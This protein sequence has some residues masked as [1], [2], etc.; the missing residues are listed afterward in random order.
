M[1]DSGNHEYYTIKV[2]TRYYEIIYSEFLLLN[3]FILSQKYGIVS[4]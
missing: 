4:K 1:H 2:Q 3:Y